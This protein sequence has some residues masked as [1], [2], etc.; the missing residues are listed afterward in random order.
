MQAPGG[1]FLYPSGDARALAARLDAL[2]GSADA[3][4]QAK[5]AALDAAKRTFCWERQEQAHSWSPSIA[6]WARL[7]DRSRG[8][9]KLRPTSRMAGQPTRQAKGLRTHCAMVRLAGKCTDLPEVCL[10]R[11]GL[12]FLAR[13]AVQVVSGKWTLCRMPPRTQ[14]G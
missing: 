14:K 13:P 10:M 7:P 5:A 2:L 3:L 11:D 4:K 8:N 1:V 6:L 9:R 12:V